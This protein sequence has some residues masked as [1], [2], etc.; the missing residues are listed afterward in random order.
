MI[1]FLIIILLVFVLPACSTNTANTQK[2]INKPF[3][4]EK[5]IEKKSPDVKLNCYESGFQWGVCAAK[6][7]EDRSCKPGEDAI[8]PENCMDDPQTQQGIK[9]GIRSI[10]KGLPQ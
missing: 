4:S 8:I 7:T 6:N 1:K 3:K 10:Q 2:E 9:D 5:L